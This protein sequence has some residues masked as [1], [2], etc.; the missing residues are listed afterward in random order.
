M[1]PDPASAGDERVC[2]SA[3]PLPGLTARTILRPQAGGSQ[4]LGATKPCGVKG[5]QQRLSE[6]VGG[7][8]PVEGLSRPGVE[9]VGSSVERVLGDGGQVGAFGE[10]LA[11]GMYG[12]GCLVWRVSGL[13]ATE[14]E[15]H[16]D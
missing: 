15:L 11:Y 7:C 14:E 16:G 13:T 9:R 5:S 1:E 8:H 4:P 10:V 2:R 6:C 3:G 12:N